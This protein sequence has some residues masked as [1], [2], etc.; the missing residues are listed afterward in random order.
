MIIYPNRKCNTG[1]MLLPS[2]LAMP[3]FD[4]NASIRHS[5]HLLVK[6]YFHFGME[7]AKWT[8][9]SIDLCWYKIYE[10]RIDLNQMKERVPADIKVAVTS[11]NDTAAVKINRFTLVLCKGQGSV[12]NMRWGKTR[13][14][15]GAKFDT[16]LSKRMQSCDQWC[17]VDRLVR[18]H[19]QL[20][21]LLLLAPAP[22]PHHSKVLKHI[23]H[24]PPHSSPTKTHTQCTQVLVRVPQLS[25]RV[26]TGT[27]QVPSI[28]P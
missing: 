24:S 5:S 9:K 20:L 17:R 7:N 14:T 13:A 19:L 11:K 4:P 27:F 2:F 16:S 3:G 28:P 22:L 26:G 25:D 23:S 18:L 15:C 12:P 21:L 1:N 6:V 10:Y 8:L